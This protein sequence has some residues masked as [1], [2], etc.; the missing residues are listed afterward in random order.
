MCSY[1]IYKYQI[2]NINIWYETK[3]LSWCNEQ[4]YCRWP[5]ENFPWLKQRRGFWQM[6]L[7]TL[8]TN[9]LCCFLIGDLIIIFLLLQL[10]KLCLILVYGICLIS[11]FLLWFCF[12]CVP[13]H[14]FN[15]VYRYLMYTTVSFIDWYASFNLRKERFSS[16]LIK[17]WNFFQS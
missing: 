17:F 15:Y 5:G 2:Y 4:S 11:F 6:H 14:N 7:R 13:L 10:W 12:S 9:S 3:S 16:W 8:I 1:K